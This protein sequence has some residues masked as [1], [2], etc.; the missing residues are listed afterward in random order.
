MLSSRNTLAL[1]LATLWL[2]SANAQFD[3]SI[4]LRNGGPASSPNLDDSRYR[5]RQPESR[6]ETRPEPRRERELDERPGTAIPSPV[7]P[8]RAAAKPKPVVKEPVAPPPPPPIATPAAQ[9]P[10]PIIEEPSPTVSTQVKELILGGSSEHIDEYKRQ[11]HPDDPRANILS[12]S[13]AP[14]YY[15]NGSNSEYSFRRYHSNGPGLGL[16]TNLW[17]TPFFGLQSKFFTSVAASQRSGGVNMVPVEVQMLEAGIRFRKHFGTSRKAGQLSWGIDYHD[18]ITKISKESTTA[19]GKKS[20][21]LA[22]A[23]EGEIPRSLTYSHIFHVDIKPR[24]KH[25][26]TKTGIELKSGTK[27][28]SS[29]VSLT[30]GGQW[31][32]DR[33]NQVFWK[34]QYVVERNL[35]DGVATEVDPHNGETP[36]GVSV[37]NSLIIFYFGFRWGS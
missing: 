12:I 15:Y 1:L 9:A 27:N 18:S 16:G 36:D 29:A 22:F 33:R 19:V 37:T 34:G 35:F 24:L 5:M 2:P 8:P 14:A 4:L 26:E 31:T 20:S 28:E 30:F 11:I 25:S 6:T 21:G 10:L 3:S 13:L 32:L 17:L 23:L 7:P